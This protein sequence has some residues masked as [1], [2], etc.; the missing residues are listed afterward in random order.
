MFRLDAGL[1]VYLHRDAVDF[2][3]NINGQR[4][5]SRSAPP[6]HCFCCVFARVFDIA[7]IMSICDSVATIHNKKEC[8]SG[9]LTRTAIGQG[10]TQRLIQ[11]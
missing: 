3:K 7:P 4:S 8:P 11:R 1:Q 9:A 10:R 2:R 6:M 5:T